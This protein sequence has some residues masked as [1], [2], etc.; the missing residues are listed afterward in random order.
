MARTYDIDG[1][2]AQVGA[3]AGIAVQG[4]GPLSSA[5]DLLR[6]ADIALEGARTA[7]AARPLWFD[8]S[9]ERALIAQSELEHA[10]RLGLEH[11]QFHP[12]FEPQVDLIT[13]RIIGFEVLARWRHPTC[14]IIGPD[15]FIPIAEHIGVI[16]RL[17]EQIIVTALRAA[18]GWDP[19]ITLSVNISPSQL[20]DPWLAQRML[21][22]LTQAG[23][24]AERLVVEIT[25]GSL[26]S[27]MELARSMLA[28][29]KNQGVRLALDDFGTG[30]SS[31]SHLRS[32]PLDVI[33]IDRSFVSSVCS[34]HESAAIVKAVCALAGAIGVPITAEGIEDAETHA[35]VLAFGAHTGQGWYFGK[36]M[37]AEQAGE[38]L[39][40][41]AGEKFRL[42]SP[43][44]GRNA[45]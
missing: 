2:L 41:D 33:K 30:Y 35:A 11:D 7:R 43:D 15:C 5:A 18:R 9:M 1:T 31:L 23:F 44:L 40:R 12:V 22:L 10:M 27:D 38:L 34:D 42:A 8:D 24:P 32:L 14:G 39:M 25:E 26:F 20:N 16:G 28:N 17:S 19:S 37:N 29:L 21:A 3:Y 36:P 6:R 4:D 13:G 45:A